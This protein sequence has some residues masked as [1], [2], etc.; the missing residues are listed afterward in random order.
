MIVEEIMKTDIATLTESDSIATAIQL[1]KTKKIR[2]IPIV[3][4]EFKLVGI[5]SDRDVRD[6]SPSIFH[7]DE[8]QEYLQKPLTSIMK[9]NVIIGHPL[10]FVEEISGLCY[11]HRISCLPIIKDGKLV[12][13]V[14]ETDLLYTFI[15]L[16]GT[17]QPGSQIE[18]KVPNTTGQLS[19]ISKIFMDRNINISSVLVY[20]DKD[21]KFKILVFRVQTMNPTGVI[22]DLKKQGYT[23]LWP[24]IPEI[25]HE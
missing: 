11:E 2:H 18:V 19:D 12:G 20:P 23:V 4:A 22:A 5:I 6:A 17:N 8:R 16:T 3:D 7:I 13:I 1:L 25:K 10:D 21:D 15:Q 14:T 9:T 24:N